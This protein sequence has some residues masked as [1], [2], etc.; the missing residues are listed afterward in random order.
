MDDLRVSG[1]SGNF[2]PFNVDDKIDSIQVIVGKGRKINVKYADEAV[3][4]AVDC[5]FEV[6]DVVVGTH[7]LK[8]NVSGPTGFWRS[9]I[10]VRGSRPSTVRAD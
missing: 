2:P 10:S 5:E 9:E 7:E 4:I 8:P 3:V 1:W 6:V